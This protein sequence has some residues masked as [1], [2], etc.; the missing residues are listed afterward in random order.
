MLNNRRNCQESLSVRE[1]RSSAIRAGST[2]SCKRS[3]FFLNIAPGVFFNMMIHTYGHVST[4]KVSTVTPETVLLDSFSL[5]R[6]SSRSQV[7]TKFIELLLR[8]QYRDYRSRE[9]STFRN[10]FRKQATFP[11]L[12]FSRAAFV[13]ILAN[14]TR[15]PMLFYI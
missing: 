1:S 5:G 6:W 14:G 10:I 15:L 4:L 9:C 13:H 12:L 7:N 11:L 3:S 8:A 2:L